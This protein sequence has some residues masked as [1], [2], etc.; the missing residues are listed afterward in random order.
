MRKN[1]LLKKKRPVRLLFEVFTPVILILLLAWIKAQTTEQNYLAGFGGDE[2]DNDLFQPYGYTPAGSSYSPRYAIPE[3]TLTGLLLYMARLSFDSNRDMQTFGDEKARAICERELVYGGRI[4]LNKSSSYAVPSECQDHVSLY[5]LAIA[6]DNA[7][8]RAYF[9]DTVKEWYPTLEI[10]VTSNATLVVPSLEDS[11]VFYDTEEDLENYIKSA[12]YGKTMEQPR[13]FGALV[14]NEFPGDASI[15]SYAPID[16]SIRMNG[17]DTEVGFISHVPSTKSGDASTWF[18]FRRGVDTAAY[19]LY[20]S[21]GFMTL[22]TLV[23]R[24]VNC[25]P[26]WDSKAKVST[27]ECQASSS[28]ASASNDLDNRLLQ[29]VKQDPSTKRAL[30]ELMGDRGMDTTIVKANSFDLPLSKGHREVLLKPLRQAPQPY[31]GATTSPFPSAAYSTSDFYR[32]FKSIMPLFFTIAYQMVL[33]KIIV[34]L[35]SERE[36]RSRELMKILGVKESSLVISWYLTHGLILLVSCIFQALMATSLLFEESDMILVFLFFFLFSLSFLAYGFM[37]SSM[38]SKARTGGYVGIIGFVVMYA[39]SNAFNDM[40]S[41]S[42]K[43]A[44]SLLSP[45]AFAFAIQ[46]LSEVET[47]HVGIQFSNASALVNRFRFSSALWMF[48]FDTFLYTLIGMYLEK[49]VPKTHGTTEKWYFPVMPSYWRRRRGDMSNESRTHDETAVHMEPNVEPVSADL[50]EQ[51]RT[52][53]A[54]CVQGLSKVFSVPGGEKVAVDDLQLNM[55]SGQI[56]C[57]LGHNGAGKTTLISILTGMLNPTAGDATFRGLSIRRNMDE[58]RESLGI[59]FQHDVLYPELTVEEHLQFYARIK[60][61]SGTEL[62]NEVTHKINEVGLSDKRKTISSALSGGMKRKLS[63][64]ISLLGDSSLVFLDEP[65]SGMDPYSRRST[66]EI[67]MNNRH[68]RV[69][70]LTTHFMDEADILGDRIAIMAE[71]QLRCCGSSLFLKNRYGAGYNL[72]IVKEEGC[73]DAKVCDFVLGHIPGGR[74]LS[75]VGMEI[76]FQLPLETSAQFP[77]LFNDI[78]A[79]LENLQVRSY[80]ISV[81]TMEEVFIKVAE[82]ANDEDVS[83][84]QKLVLGNSMKT[85]KVQ[86]MDSGELP[87]LGSTDSPVVKSKPTSMFALHLIALVQK[88]YRIAKRDKRFGFVSLFLPIALLVSGIALLKAGTLSKPNLL[89]PLSIDSLQLQLPSYCD[90]PSEDWCNKVFSSSDFTGGAPVILGTNDIGNPPYANNSPTVLGFQYYSPSFNHTGTTGQLLKLTQV[91]YD[92]AI[93]QGVDNQFGGFLVHADSKS[94]VLSYNVLVNTT[95][96]HGSAVFKGLMD[97]SIYRIM[98]S[99]ASPSVDVSKLYLK[100]NNYPLPQSVLPSA[101]FSSYLGILV[102]LLI[103]IAFVFFP[104]PIV[105]LLVKER[106]AEHNSKHQQLVS[107]VNLLGF[108]LSNYLWDL[109]VYIIPG[110]IALLLIQVFDVA[111]LSGSSDCVSCTSETFPAVVV[112]FV[113]FGL[114]ICPYSYSLSFL[115]RQHTSAQNKAITFNFLFGLVFIGLSLVLELIPDVQVIGRALKWVFRL[116]PIYN[117]GNG[118]LI[119]VSMEMARNGATPFE[120]APWLSPFSTENAGYEILSLGVDAV[121][122][123]GVAVGIDYARSFPKVKSMFTKKPSV[124]SFEEIEDTDV[125]AEAKRVATGQADGDMIML[126]NLRKVYPNGD[127]VAVKNLSFGLKRG[128]CFGFLGINGAGKTTTMKMLTGDIVPTS[129]SATLAGFDILSQ[130]IDVRREIGYCPQFDALIDLLSVREHLELFAQIKGVPR[131]ELD[132]VVREKMQ[133]LNLTAFEHKLAGSLSGGNKRKLSVAIAMIGSPSILFLDEPSTGMDPVSRRFMWDVISEISTYNKQ[134][135]VVLTTHS[136]EE[137]EALCT[138]VG[139]MVGG[140][141]KCLGSVQHLKHRFGDGLMFDAKLLPAPVS[142]VESLVLRHFD[143][144]D[145]RISALELSDVCRRFGESAWEEKL[146]ETHPTGF[147]VASALR[148]DGYVLAGS[149]ASWWLTE[150]R[151]AGVER[152]LSSNFARVE[153]LE[154]Q[155]ESCRF[156][157][158]D[159]AIGDRVALSRLSLGHVFGLLESSKASLAIREYSVS[160]TTLEQIFNTFASQQHAENPMDVL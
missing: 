151:F 119:I 47:A 68:N 34:T 83:G 80:G 51:E 45:T 95:L 28:L 37:V 139:I 62:D 110:G 97:Q 112:L 107:G 115:L 58:I 144:L 114:A 86:T 98:A 158:H 70:V 35:I 78:D 44:A 15:G 142:E 54:L 16:Y 109:L 50:A 1:W 4:S 40:S 123:F 130:Q 134:S 102:C 39:V 9:F 22:Q 94:R 55:Y 145:A 43:N 146:V 65:T 132:E 153:L 60:G 72:T 91:I 52:G 17:T 121:L 67:L 31:L 104:A 24:F 3:T 89:M 25:M 138:R 129:G 19:K 57:L 30:S 48:V 61:Y 137:C 159:V 5:K 135:T 7:F 147:L 79:N 87:I 46:V 21:G 33:S 84:H 56:T 53:A 64:A 59:C 154:R 6:P 18:P 96:D 90:Q 125:V 105:T 126:Q 2:S 26:K 73:D 27:G 8:T 99:E 66:W 124:E 157:L 49:V 155:N 81:T 32:T 140:G 149:F 20:A 85:H 150:V 75:N 10:N 116:C 38:F 113:L 141:L 74:V 111:P 103:V 131:S 122:L 160:Q 14:F 42:S 152:F 156:K 92:R 11:V 117:L 133:Q 63:V 136:M 143:S 36:T 93:E 12:T 76:A 100:V 106:Q 101:P 148:R 13:I 118:L 82:A 88:R 128:E 108:W 120:T 127:K 69:L 23:T 71:G 29:T 41:E 77:S